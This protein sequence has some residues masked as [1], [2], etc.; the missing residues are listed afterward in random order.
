VFEAGSGGDE[1]VSL[2]SESRR[3]AINWD[4]NAYCITFGVLFD[5]R[6]EPVAREALD[7]VRVCVE[8]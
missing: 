2:V 5:E 7:P 4:E 6:Q 8:G 1:E 3:S